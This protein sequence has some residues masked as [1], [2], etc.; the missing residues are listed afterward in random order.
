MLVKRV[1]PAWHVEATRLVTG[2]GPRQLRGRPQHG[3]GR[4][5]AA[6][7]GSSGDRAAPVGLPRPS[8]PRGVVG[9]SAAANRARVRTAATHGRTAA[10]RR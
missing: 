3:S 6:A 7:V 8:K 1:V 10:L 4:A 5:H 2:V 9:T